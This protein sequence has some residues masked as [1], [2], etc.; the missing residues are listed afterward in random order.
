MVDTKS[1]HTEEKAQAAEEEGV[2]SGP[3]IAPSS[4]DIP[5]QEE[6]AYIVHKSKRKWIWIGSGLLLTCITLLAFI[7][8][9]NRPGI[10]TLFKE[11][12]TV[13]AEGEKPTEVITEGKPISRVA[14]A[15]NAV[16][17][18]PD[19]PEAHLHL[20]EVYRSEGMDQKA[21]DQYLEAGS[22]LIEQNRF[23]DGVD[24][25]S[26]AILLQGGLKDADKAV[27]EKVEEILFLSASD[28]NLAPVYQHTA[29][30]FP[31]WDVVKICEARSHVYRGEFDRAQFILDEI[32]SGLPDHLLMS[33][34]RSELAFMRGM[35]E[36]ALSQVK[37]LLNKPQIPEWLREHL[38][39]LEREIRSK[40]ERPNDANSS[41]GWKLEDESDQPGSNGVA[42]C[43]A[44]WVG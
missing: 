5:A 36:E 42:R 35:N 21:V 32:Q 28:V 43:D 10:R 6:P 24:A 25:L 41:S 16:S 13:T 9:A 15:E 34:V 12:R 14:Q 39:K 31:N 19:D 7:A 38:Q 40:M 2:I 3:P 8:I 20:A 18:R 37:V 4:Q 29:E 17:E 26:E 11:D 22:L 44:A 33:T 23:E 1:I 27:V 30:R